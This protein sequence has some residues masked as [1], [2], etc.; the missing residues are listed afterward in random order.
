MKQLGLAAVQYSQDFDEAL[1]PSWIGNSGWGDGHPGRQR[2]TDLLWVYTKSDEVFN[3]PDN[4][5]EDAKY[6]RTWPEGTPQ[7]AATAFDS[8]SFPGSYGMNNTYWDGSDGVTAPSYGIGTWGNPTVRTM[9]D[10][11]RPADTIHL[12]ETGWYAYPDSGWPQTGEV[13]WQNKMSPRAKVETNIGRFPLLGG[14]EARHNGGANVSFVDG[15]AKW[16][17]LDALAK[18]N[19]N[20]ILPM[21]TN[22]ED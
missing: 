9:A 12:I 13:A 15:H 6:R 5:K 19:A 11:K 22:E 16:F 3:C 14:A 18:P 21:W 10:V 4:A 17:K 1:V 20:N 7:H 8:A 2:W